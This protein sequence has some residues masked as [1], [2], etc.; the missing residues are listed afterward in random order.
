MTTWTSDE[1]TTE[2]VQ[3]MEEFVR[4]LHLSV[5]GATNQQTCV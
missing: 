2:R 4:S 3:E 5:S 1:L